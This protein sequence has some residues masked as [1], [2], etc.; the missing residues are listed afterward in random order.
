MSIDVKAHAKEIVDSL[1][2]VKG[3]EPTEEQIV[4]MVVAVIHPV[5]LGIAALERI[6]DALEHIAWQGKGKPT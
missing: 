6:A 1:T 5:L 2:A 4:T 3:N